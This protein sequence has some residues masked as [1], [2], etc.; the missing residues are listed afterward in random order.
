MA[1]GADI[2]ILLAML[3]IVIVYLS[4]PK[5]P[6][7][8]SVQESSFAVFIFLNSSNSSKEWDITCT[9]GIVVNKSFFL[10]FSLY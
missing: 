2:K 10:C 8:P 6:L 7:N 9:S 1:F 5:S 3:C 4:C